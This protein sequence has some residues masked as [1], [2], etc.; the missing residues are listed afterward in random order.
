[1][2]TFLKLNTEACERMWRRARLD[3]MMKHGKSIHYQISVA[4]MRKISGFKRKSAAGA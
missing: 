2:I 4:W 3:S 1:M